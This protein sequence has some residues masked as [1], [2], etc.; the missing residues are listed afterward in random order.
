MATRGR[1]R[2]TTLNL[3]PLALACLCA[4][5]IVLAL[6]FAVT[7]SGEDEEGDPPPTA[8]ALALLD[9]ELDPSPSASPTPTPP[10]RAFAV[11]PT[12]TST[13]RVIKRPKLSPTPEP[14]ATLEPTP[15]VDPYGPELVAN[16]GFETTDGVWYVEQG[17]NRATGDAHDG[18]A[19][20]LIDAGGGYADQRIVVEAGVTYEVVVW[21]AVAA[22][23]R[24]EI[25]VRFEDARFAS[26]AADP[27][28]RTVS[29]P[30]WTSI[31]FTFV[32]PAGAERALI[33]FW[34]PG[35]GALA[36]D[37]VS[38]RSRTID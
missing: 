37:E 22:G 38:V 21:V 23:G 35:G 33:S 5:A 10:S 1:S 6:A 26:V 28:Q 24:G 3:N 20:L 30:G 32:A 31:S 27:I 34:N 19:Y 4:G 36:I 11:E 18:A 14:T 9:A 16:G 17:A 15:T 8:V 12:P 25:G 29:E 7:S 2:R 13:P